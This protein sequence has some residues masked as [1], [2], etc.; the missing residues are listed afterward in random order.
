MTQLD[1][2]PQKYIYGY[3]ICG[4]L[5]FNILCPRLDF[6]KIVREFFSAETEIQPMVTS[7]AAPT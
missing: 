6:K 1:V 3:D 4:N 5:C 2:I 7:P